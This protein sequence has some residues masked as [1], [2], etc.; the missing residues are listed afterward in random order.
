MFNRIFRQYQETTGFYK[1]FSDNLGWGH[2]DV[3]N[4]LITTNVLLTRVLQRAH[5]RWYDVRFQIVF[6]HF[7]NFIIYN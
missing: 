3:Q 7:I 5:D 1:Y 2:T 6:S 4:A